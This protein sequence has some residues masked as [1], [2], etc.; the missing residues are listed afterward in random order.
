MSDDWK[1]RNEARRGEE[2][3][4]EADLALRWQKSRRSLQRWR[5]EGVGPPYH[6]IGHAVRYRVSDVRAYEAGVR[7][8]GGISK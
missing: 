1:E 4:S 7:Q 2:F 8:D 3:L 6:R 5:A